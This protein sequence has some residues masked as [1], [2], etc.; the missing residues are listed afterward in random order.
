M[1]GKHSFTLDLRFSPSATV[2]RSATI[3]FSWLI[4]SVQAESLRSSLYEL[5]ALLGKYSPL[6]DAMTERALDRVIQYGVVFA[7][8]SSPRRKHARN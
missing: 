8:V 5:E 4:M 7:E 1:V 3:D 2:R 6:V